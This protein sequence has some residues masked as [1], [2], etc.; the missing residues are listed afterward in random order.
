MLSN[1]GPLE[2]TFRRLS[3]FMIFISVITTGLIMYVISGMDGI[4]LLTLFLAW[5]TISIAC[6]F[7]VRIYVRRQ[8][9]HPI[10]VIIDSMNSFVGGISSSRVD[11]QFSNAFE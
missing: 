9:I 1:K 5:F 11:K 7:F 4:D 3:L 10:N 8:V 6:I 2:R